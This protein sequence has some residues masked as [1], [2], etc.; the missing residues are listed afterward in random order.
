MK[1]RLL[2][3]LVCLVFMPG[4]TVALNVS[5]IVTDEANDPI[6]GAS[7]ICKGTS[8]GTATDI[9]GRFTLDVPESGATIQVSYVG[10]LPLELPDRKSVV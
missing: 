5:G 8:V 6:V 9:D 4:L 7:V 10:M 2:L 1:S 3:L